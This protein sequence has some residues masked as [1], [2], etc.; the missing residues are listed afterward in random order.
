V[1]LLLGT[2]VGIGAGITV[3]TGVCAAFWWLESRR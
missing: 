2:L 3:Y 1:T